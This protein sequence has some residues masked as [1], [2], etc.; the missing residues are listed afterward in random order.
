MSHAITYKTHEEKYFRAKAFTTTS[1]SGPAR[2]WQLFWYSSWNT[3]MGPLSL[4]TLQTVPRYSL[5][6]SFTLSYICLFF[7]T[8]SHR[9]PTVQLAWPFQVKEPLVFDPD[10]RGFVWSTSQHSSPVALDNDS[11]WQEVGKDFPL[12]GNP[13]DASPQTNSSASR[14]VVPETT[15]ESTTLIL[16]HLV[17]IS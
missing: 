2:D 6:I 9:T 5:I 4:E 7:L 15:H 12:K 13:L 8:W 10:R 1:R 14:L 16:Q 17:I 3:V 11:I